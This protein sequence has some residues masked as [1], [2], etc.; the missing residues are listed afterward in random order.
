M[1]NNYWEDVYQS[2]QVDQLSWYQ[3]QDQ[4]TLELIRS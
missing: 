2:K 1:S 3:Q 4:K